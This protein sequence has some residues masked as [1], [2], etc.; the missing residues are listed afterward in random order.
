M[1]SIRITARGVRHLNKRELRRLAG[2]AE[3]E[4]RLVIDHIAR[5][6]R[7][8]HEHAALLYEHSISETRRRWRA[9]A[10]KTAS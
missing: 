5:T 3:R 6:L 9:E 10:L 1:S 4:R 7:L 8:S 2:A